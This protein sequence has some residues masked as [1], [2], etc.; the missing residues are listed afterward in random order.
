MDY[1][2]P[3]YDEPEKV[4]GIQEA[5]HCWSVMKI[6]HALPNKGGILDQDKRLMDIIIIIESEFQKEQIELMKEKEKP[7]IKK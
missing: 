4:L 2:C 5:L 3:R 6:C 1:Y 7:R